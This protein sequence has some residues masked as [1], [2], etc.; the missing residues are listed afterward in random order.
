[1]RVVVRAQVRVRMQEAPPDKIYD[2]IM[3]G[4]ETGKIEPFEAYDRDGWH[5]WVEEWKPEC[6]EAYWSE[7]RAKKN[8]EDEEDKRA[9]NQAMGHFSKDLL[10]KPGREPDFEDWLDT[11]GVYGYQVLFWKE[12][13]GEDW[14][15]WTERIPLGEGSDLSFGLMCKVVPGVKVK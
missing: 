4:L 1:M 11:Y 3:G 13:P 9:L 12:R 8:G 5:V 6:I 10:D 2:E 14:S 7:A 15:K